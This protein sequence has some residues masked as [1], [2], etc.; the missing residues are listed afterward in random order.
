MRTNPFDRFLTPEDHLHSQVVT[1]LRYQYP[2]VFWM[3]VPNEGKRSKFEQYKA[4]KL[5]ITAGVPDLLIF[6]R[7][8]RNRPSLSNV[9]DSSGLAIELKVKPNKVTANQEACM[10]KLQNVGWTC[11]VAYS[12]DEAKKTIDEYLS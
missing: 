9:P 11:K 4:K 1:Y 8:F 12:F 5:G 2:K 3:H 7:G 6:N 10:I